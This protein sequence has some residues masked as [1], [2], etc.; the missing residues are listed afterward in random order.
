MK[1]HLYRE[2]KE[3][4]D[5]T[6]TPFLRGI[7]RGLVFWV[8]MPAEHT[9]GSEQ[10]KRR[11]WVVVSSDSLH[12]RMSIVQAVPLTSQRHKADG[13]LGC[14]IEITLADFVPSDDGIPLTE[15]GVALTEQVRV[16]AHERLDGQPAGKLSQAAMARIDT[17]LR[18]VFRI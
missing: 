16:L 15:D 14:R 3:L 11:P 18:F 9:I 4:P 7:N 12:Q 10:Y 5:G 2:T 6:R 13:F 1:I 17:G 8:D